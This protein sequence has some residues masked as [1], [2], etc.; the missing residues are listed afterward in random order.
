MALLDISS[1]TQTLINLITK[2]VTASSV[3]PDSSTLTASPEPSDQLTGDNTIGL[4]LYH[5]GE[6]FALKNLSVGDD[7]PEIRDLPMDLNLHYQLTAHSDIKGPTGTYQEQLMMG[8]AMK[9]LRD[10][11]VI[12][13]STEVAGATIMPAAISGQGNRLRISLSAV[14]ENEAVN[15]WTPGSSPMRWASYYVALATLVEPEEQPRHP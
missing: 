5:I 9:A 4:Y 7:C 11:P 6:A 8:L 1:V 12:D 10:L 3:W 14:G 13:D 2:H 15:F